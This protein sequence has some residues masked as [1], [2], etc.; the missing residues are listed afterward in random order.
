MIAT[1][2]TRLQAKAAFERKGLPE[3][4][5]EEYRFATIT[6]ILEKNIK[7]NESDQVKSSIQ[8]ITEFELPTVD[9]YK[10]VFINGEYSSTL[11]QIHTSDFII[12]PLDEE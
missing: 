2:P 8:S 9:A 5:S 7:L 10:I 4:K 6:R 12:E 3:G 1:T 11:S